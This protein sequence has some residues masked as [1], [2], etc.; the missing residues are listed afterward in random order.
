RSIPPE[1]AEA[2]KAAW[3]DGP[4][5]LKR[6]GEEAIRALH[7]LSPATPSLRL[8]V[9][10]TAKVMSG[11]MR[12]LDGIALLVDAPGRSLSPHPCFRLSVPDWLPSLINAA[13]AFV[14][15]GAA[16]AFW[17]ISAWPNGLVAVLILAVLLL[18]LPPLG[19]LAVA[20]AAAFAVIGPVSIVFAAVMK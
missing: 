2:R 8:L 1:L 12:A 15:V 4:V 6:S 14:M 16:E 10:E 7:A 19:D 18:L 20:G 3:I 17:V 11:L 5:A 9:D 13:R